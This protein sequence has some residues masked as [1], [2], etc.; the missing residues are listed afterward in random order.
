LFVLVSSFV[1]IFVFVLVMYTRLKADQTV[2]FSVHVKLSYRIVSY[3]RTVCI[4]GAVAVV[5]RSGIASKRTK[6]ETQSLSS[7]T[8]PMT[9]S[10]SIRMLD[11]NSKY[12]PE[13]SL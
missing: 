1:H 13:D 12:V 6:I 5:V 7:Q 8:R 11:Q 3:H 2:S 10:N 4:S 9:G